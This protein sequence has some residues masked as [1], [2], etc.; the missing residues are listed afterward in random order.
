MTPKDQKDPTSDLV[1]GDY[2]VRFEA[3]TLQDIRA[4]G[5][6][7]EEDDLKFAAAARVSEI[8]LGLYRMFMQPWIRNFANDGLAERMRRAHPLRLQYE[9]FT[10][11]NPFM[12]PLLS[13][14]DVMRPKRRETLA[15][16]PLW[17]MQERISEWIETSLNSYRDLRDNMA[18]AMFHAVYGSPFLHALVGL[19]ASDVAP[20]RGPGKSASHLAFVAARID[21]LKRGI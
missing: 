2:L 1:A 6:N 18:E 11:A 7:S 19:K 16:N 5:G 13:S 14:L 20:Q 8:N 12:R 21:E 10:Y 4:L 15:H 9:M 17:E 3:R